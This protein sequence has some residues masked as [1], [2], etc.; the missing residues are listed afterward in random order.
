[1][2][3]VTSYDTYKITT[4]SRRAATYS[5]TIISSWSWRSW[6]AN[7]ML[8]AWH[9]LF[10]QC[11]CINSS[12]NS[13]NYFLIPWILWFFWDCWW[14][15]FDWASDCS[16]FSHPKRAGGQGGG[17]QYVTQRYWAADLGSNS[18]PGIT[19]EAGGSQSHT[20]SLSNVTSSNS[21]NLAPYYA[22][23]MIMRIAWYTL[24]RRTEASLIQCCLIYLS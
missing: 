4:P 5:V 2:R 21:N 1:M 23:T 18:N 8:V 14:G 7:F 22:L 6:G 24:K 16:T 20:H 19:Y 10:G 12:R 13:W 9:F 15:N 3:G 11:G 17:D